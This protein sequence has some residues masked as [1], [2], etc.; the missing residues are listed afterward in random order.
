MDGN[1]LL[2]RQVHPKFVQGDKVTSQAFRPTPKDAGRLSVYD[3]DQI[4][5]EPAWQHYTQELG[6]QSAGVMAI[7]GAECTAVTLPYRLTG[8]PFPEHAEVDFTAL[9]TNQTEKASKKLKS[10]AEARGWLYRAQ[11]E[12]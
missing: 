12:E 3:G 7:T 2:L 9:N 5:P 4:E 1:T 6:H 8:E 10:K 11:A